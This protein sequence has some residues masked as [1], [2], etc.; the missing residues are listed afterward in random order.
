MKEYGYGAQTIACSRKT[1]KVVSSN[2]VVTKEG[3]MG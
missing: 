3:A 1:S 2:R